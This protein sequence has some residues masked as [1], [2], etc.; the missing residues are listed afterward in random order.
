MTLDDLHQ[1][2]LFSEA[3][4]DSIAVQDALGLK[5]TDEL[6]ENT[7]LDELQFY[8]TR[9]GFS[10][11]HALGWVGQLH[12]AVHFMTDFTYGRKA[13]DAGV[14][15]SHHLLYNVENY[16]IR[17]VSVYDRCLQLTNAV[18]HICMSDELV[19]H[20]AIV[21]NLHVSRTEVPKLLKAVKKATK[22]EEQER[23]KLIHRHS[24]MDP[25]LRRIE[26]LYM[27]TKETWGDDH[28]FPYK[29][30]VHLRSQMVKKFTARRK[31]E[32][33]AINAELVKA[34]DALFDGL[35]LEY[36]RQKSRLEKLV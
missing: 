23:H 35:L 15:K 22:N 31:K 29:N 21:S 20:S 18:F 16:L 27:Q 14:K 4:R 13:T 34:L 1:H 5:L 12:Q 26:L 8:V 36:R 9:V 33:E 2:P 6:D 25:E 11:A 17:M 24:H 3:V 30:L 28:K 32:F 19:N 7:T 10:L